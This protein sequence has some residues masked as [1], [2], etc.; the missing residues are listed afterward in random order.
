[1]YSL[2]I[3]SSV[4]DAHRFI[5]FLWSFGRHFGV[6]PATVRCCNSIRH[7]NQ[8]DS[9]CRRTSVHSVTGIIIELM[10]ARPHASMLLM[11]RLL[12]KGAFIE[13]LI[14]LFEGS[15]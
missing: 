14:F 12:K 5:R 13:L 9:Q 2:G 7:R 10:R 1:M 3:C 15:S 8:G 6:V 4:A 11:Y